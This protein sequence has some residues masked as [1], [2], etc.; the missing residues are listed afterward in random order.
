MQPRDG[1]TRTPQRKKNQ[2]TIKKN[3]EVRHAHLQITISTT[4]KTKKTTERRALTCATGDRAKTGAENFPPP[5][6][7]DKIKKPTRRNL[8]GKNLAHRRPF[9]LSG[10][11]KILSRSLRQTGG[12]GEKGLGKSVW[13][14]KPQTLARPKDSRALLMQGTRNPPPPPP[15]LAAASRNQPQLW[16]RAIEPL[17]KIFFGGGTVGAEECQKQG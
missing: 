4:E 16:A 13:V 17:A 12:L 6:R 8:K 7:A 5:P 1:I 15:R 11:R 9:L 2:T 10:V 3:A 14:F